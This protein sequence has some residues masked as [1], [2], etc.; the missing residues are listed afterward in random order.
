MNPADIDHSTCVGRK[1]DGGEDK[2]WKP[3]VYREHQCC[4]AV[5]D[6]SDLCS[7]CT[8]RQEKAAET[9]KGGAWNGRVT[10]DPPSWCHML[11]TAISA[12]C[13]WNPDGASDS[14]SVAS[15]HSSTAEKMDAKKEAAAA[16]AA[17]KEAAAAAKK[18]AAAAAKAEKAAA[19]PKKEKKEKK[20]KAA[21]AATSSSNAAPAVAD[22]SA[23]VA[24]VEGE[25]EIIGHTMY[26]V[27]NGNAYEYDEESKKV[28]AFMGR[29]TPAG[30]IDEDAD[31]EVEE[32]SDSE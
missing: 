26:W 31:E 10:E 11:G 25:V 15:S 21:A 32:E 29:K 30:D 14:A 18:E 8:S 2:R 6:G 22:T 23:P 24:T 5:D 28:G 9:G 3:V 17:K 1:L 16:A 20:S 13:K 7:G 19:A 12:K 27:R 4:K